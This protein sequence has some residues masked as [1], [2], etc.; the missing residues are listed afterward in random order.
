M[1]RRRP[2][3]SKSELEVARILWGLGGGTVRQVFEALPGDRRI[4][5]KTVQTYLRRLETKGYLR[6]R[7]DGKG[8]IYSPRVEPSR[9]IGETVDDLVSRVFDGEPLSLFQHLIEDRGLR[10]EEL[11]KLRVMLDNREARDES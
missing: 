11:K 6:A 7:L 2:S 4:D 1:T 10:P 3:L 5:F 9:V 8:L